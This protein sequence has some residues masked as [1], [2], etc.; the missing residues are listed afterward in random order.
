[1][2]L[3]QILE[4]INELLFLCR[5]VEKSIKEIQEYII[6]QRK[7]MHKYKVIT[8]DGELETMAV[9]WEMDKWDGYAKFFDRDDKVVLCLQRD[10]IRGV[11]IVGD[12]K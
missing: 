2:M 1:M 12:E 8:D 9:D 11:S 6:L 7:V 5:S 3:K 4:K 10:I